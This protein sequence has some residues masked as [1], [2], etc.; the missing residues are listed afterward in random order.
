M[1]NPLIPLQTHHSLRFL[2][3]V[4][5]LFILVGIAG[6][7]PEY[8]LSGLARHL[9]ET[10]LAHTPAGDISAL[11]VVMFDSMTNRSIAA[12]P[13]EALLEPS[14]L[15]AERYLTDITRVIQ[16]LVVMDRVA[17]TT[18]TPPDPDRLRS[19]IY[20]AAEAVWVESVIQPDVV[21]HPADIHHYYLAHPELFL[22]RI[23]AQV[24]YIFIRV[25]DTLNPGQRRQAREQLEMIASGIRRGEMNFKD[26]AAQY[27]DA[28]SS[29]VG[30]LIPPFYNGTYFQEFED[31]SFLLDESGG[32]SRVFP[33]PGGY[34]LIQL[35]S[36]S[37]P[38]N[39]AIETVSGEIRQKL[40]REHIRHFYA[41]HFRKIR[42]DT[43]VQ[44][45]SGLWEYLA[46]TV[47]IAEFESR[48]LGRKEFHKL[49]G[50]MIGSDYSVDMGAV[51]HHIR[52]WIEGE[53][54]L[55]ELGK[56][57]LD[58]HSWIERAR[59][60]ATIK[61]QADRVLVDRVPPG[62]YN[63]EESAI[64]TLDENTEFRKYL[65]RCRLVSVLLEMEEFD[66]LPEP[67]LK[68]VQGRMNDYADQ[69]RSGTLPGLPDALDLAGWMNR[70]RTGQVDMDSGLKELEY[71]RKT[72]KPE[73]FEVSFHDL[74]WVSLLPGNPLL[75]PIGTMDSGGITGPQAHSPNPVP[76]MSF[77]LIIDSEPISYDEIGRIPLSL[78]TL[79]LN[80]ELSRM[81]EDERNQIPA[82]DRI[83]TLF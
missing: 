39:I 41:Q 78:Q 31:A 15:R 23:E 3:P 7:A 2:I 1:I 54:I 5:L 80:A 49:F 16:D 28:D 73:G 24:R 10:S 64:R 81:L 26:A 66:K 4:F 30:G 13:I 61:L 45:R 6:S 20:G 57:G 75:E 48:D 42:E 69:L 22:Q 12:V 65:R 63:S 71:T 82:E 37:Q 25:R 38:S 35:V 76:S 77:Y 46:R 29:S 59:E 58:S 55:V 14:T 60:L 74:D 50:N 68:T 36:R 17:R 83:R 51:V 11:D 52:G 47:P 21:V 67:E 19:M 79:A 53:M 70:V 44:D 33:G 43:V 9:S 32:L 8:V 18:D 56:L 27:S 40:T 72:E 62:R 34:Y